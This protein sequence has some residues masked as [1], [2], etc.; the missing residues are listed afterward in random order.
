MNV[1]SN[2]FF[3]MRVPIDIGLLKCFSDICRAYSSVHK[4]Y[5]TSYF[6]WGPT[7]SGSIQQFEAPFKH[8]AAATLLLFALA[9]LL[10]A[11]VVGVMTY[12]LAMGETAMQP[13]TTGL[14]LGVVSSLLLVAGVSY[15]LL[16]YSHLDGGFYYM[17]G[18]YATSIVCLMNALGAGVCALAQHGIRRR[19]YMAIQSTADE[20]EIN[21]LSGV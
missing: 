15:A 8:A 4:T 14:T 6:E 5:E 3:T 18:F 9:S 21:K 16:T 17:G 10:S 7:A 11:V 20:I 13:S 2:P 1:A 19:G 12:S